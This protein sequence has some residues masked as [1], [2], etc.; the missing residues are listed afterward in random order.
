VWKAG[1]EDFRF[2][3]YLGLFVALAVAVM[4]FILLP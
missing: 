2:L 4:E 3:V 1:G